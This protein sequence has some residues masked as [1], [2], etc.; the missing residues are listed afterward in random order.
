VTSGRP[1]RR[2]RPGDEPRLAWERRRGV[3]GEAPWWDPADQ[4]WAE[5]LVLPRRCLGRGWVDAAMINN[6]ER[7]DPLAGPASA[8][9]LAARAARGV[10][11]LDE[12]RAWRR[13]RDGV[14]AVL[15]VEVLGSAD[16]VAHRAA[17]RSTGEA[18]LEDTWR[19]R[20]QERDRQAGWVEARWVPVDGTGPLD[21]HRVDWLHLEDHTEAA[22]HDAVMAYEHLVVWLGRAQ[23]TLTIRHRE[24]LDL[25]DV[26][27]SAG[28]VLADVDP[29]PAR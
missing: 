21:P 6:V 24:G 15:R 25:D 18:A 8:P 1:R 28:A 10:V 27:T 4:A 17:W 20:W 13:R 5:D 26:V 9:V 11:A 16:D 19:T 14:L 3:E 23:A 7:P 29:P 12:G 22:E 2:A